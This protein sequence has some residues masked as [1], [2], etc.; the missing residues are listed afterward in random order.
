MYLLVR[1]DTLPNTNTNKNTNTLAKCT[2]KIPCEDDLMYTF[3]HNLNTACDQIS[4]NVIFAKEWDTKINEEK[5]CMVLGHC[6]KLRSN[7]VPLVA[8]HL[9]QYHMIPEHF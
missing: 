8:P 5:S 6:L 9:H 2:E 1:A 4:Q 7:L 3:F